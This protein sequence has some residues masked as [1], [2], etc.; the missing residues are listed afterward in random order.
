MQTKIHKTVALLDTSAI[1]ALLKSEP[2]YEKLE[3]VLATSAISAA[4]LAELVTVLSRSGVNEEEIDEIANNIVPQVIPLSQEIAILSG[5]L[6]NQ[7]RSLG[8]SL[9]DRIC[10]ATGIALSLPIYTTDKIW[11]EL[12]INAEIIVIR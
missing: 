8:L 4:N 7:T 12:N 11:Q 6:N 2:G 1:I 5:K 10:I 9:G 3:S